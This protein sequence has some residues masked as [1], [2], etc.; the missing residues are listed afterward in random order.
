MTVDYTEE[1]MKELQ[2]FISK[3]FQDMSAQAIDRGGFDVFTFINTWISV[4]N[5]YKKEAQK[6]FKKMIK[7]R[8][9]FE[10]EMEAT[11]ENYAPEI[12]PS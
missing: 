6:Q 3:S 11:E 7:N 8:K 9:K 4:G 5:I 12:F 2:I 1:Q 10:E